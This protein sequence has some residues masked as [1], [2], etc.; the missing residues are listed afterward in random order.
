M[1]TSSLSM[2]D[3]S[4]NIRASRGTFTFYCCIILMYA[5]NKQVNINMVER[6]TQKPREAEQT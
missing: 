5:S 6:F 4:F 2:M 1:F 3:L